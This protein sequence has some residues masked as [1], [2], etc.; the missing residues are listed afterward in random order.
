[1]DRRVSPRAATFC[2]WPPAGSTARPPLMRARLFVA[3]VPRRWAA[4]AWTTDAQI[5]PLLPWPPKTS[6]LSSSEPT[7]W[8]SPL[9]MSTVISSSTSL[10]AGF[11]FL[12][13]LHHAFRLCR[14]RLS[15]DDVST[16]GAGDRAAQHQQVL[17][18]VN[19]DDREVAHRH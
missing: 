11:R 8:F 9:T 1:M 15:D 12:D 5:N 3:C 7:L 18:S 6:S 19:L 16:R 17:V 13:R 2:R 4:F 14:N 10:L